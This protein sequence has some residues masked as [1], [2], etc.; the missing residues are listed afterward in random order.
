VFRLTQ[1][2]LT[3]FVC[4]GSFGSEAVLSPEF[5]AQKA[6][7][8]VRGKV[9][10]KTFKRDLSKRIVTEV[11][12]QVSEVWKGEVKGSEI[13]LTQLGGILGEEIMTTSAQANYA[14]D[15]DVLLFLVKSDNGSL[16]TV[17]AGHGKYQIDGSGTSATGL[18]GN[19][20][21]ISELKKIVSK[22]Q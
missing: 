8:V 14:I 4:G 5:L 12:V 18:G 17:S 6:E 10:S 15:E 9:L 19:L 3:L 21:Q 20:I 22:K 13:K 7:F 16:I 11:E 1:L 2:I